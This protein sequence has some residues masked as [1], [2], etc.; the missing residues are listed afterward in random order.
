MMRLENYKLAF[1]AVG[2]VGVL[3]FASPTLSQVF[4]VPGSE[5]FS[6]LYLL[7]PEHMASDIPF[8]VKSG[9]NYPVYLG[10]GNHMAA[11]MYYVCYVKLRNQT[12][13]LPN[14]TTGIP[15]SLTPLFEY[16]AFVQ[17][18]KTWEAPLNFSVSN[19]SVANNESLLESIT[20]NNVKFDVA[21]TAQYDQESNGYYYQLFIEL[22]AFNPES[23]IQ[24]HSR[25]V[26]FWF[27]VTSTL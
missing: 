25:Y 4:T 17:D 27:N 16:R 20:I 13:P 1:I 22:W 26:S 18:E 7:G 3:L 11:S 21:K 8:S 14:A 5:K 24:Y 19:I 10:V 23:T 9:V 12:D 2:L 6:E 15:S